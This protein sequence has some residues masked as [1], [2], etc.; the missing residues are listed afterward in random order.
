MT[1]LSASEA[2]KRLYN[3][4]DEVKDT[5]L[6]V[7]IIGKRNSAVLISEDDWR[8]IE[9]TLYLTAIPGMRESIKKGLKTPVDK[10]DKELKW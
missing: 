6:P 4:V 7:Q 8:A 2:R 3:L 10:C 1:T 5:H 9:E